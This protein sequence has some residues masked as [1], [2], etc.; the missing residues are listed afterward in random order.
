MHASLGRLARSR[1]VRSR[2]AVF[3]LIAVVAALVIPPGRAAEAAAGLAWSERAPLP[4]PR[5]SLSVA[6]AAGG[7]IYAIGG[8]ASTG[9][10]DTVEVYDPFSDMWTDRASLLAVRS[11]HAVASA[12]NGMIYS[13]SGNTPGNA[14]TSELFEYN[15]SADE[16]TTKANIPTPRYLL[17]AAA[18]GDSIYA[19]G[20]VAVGY[21]P[22]LCSAAFE[23]YSPASN[24]WQAKAQ[25][26]TARCSTAAATAA[27]GKIYVV[28]GTP[29]V[30]AIRCQQSRLTTLQMTAGQRRARCRI[31]EMVW[32]WSH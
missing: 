9:V 20:G 19:I 7:Q 27:D 10:T 29:S 8:D 5:Q 13:I 4:T 24:A 16:W 26:P 23:E 14:L 30:P 31:Q 15:P 25:M 11:G 28:G 12:S 17:T 6:V 21:S 2:R 1:E 32:P 18:A 3:S 22:Y